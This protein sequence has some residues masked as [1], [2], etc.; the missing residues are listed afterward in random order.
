MLSRPR[1]A[2]APWPSRASPRTST[3]TALL[4]HR[5]GCCCGP[6]PCSVH[7]CCPCHLHPRRRPCRCPCHLHPRRRPCHLHPRRR[8]PR[9]LRCPPGHLRRP[10]GGHP[11]RR[12]RR[13]ARL[14]RAA[15]QDRGCRPCRP[16][17]GCPPLR[18]RSPRRGSLP[19]R[20]PCCSC[21]CCPCCCC[22]CC[23]CSCCCC[24]P[25]C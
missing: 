12:Q 22:P 7:P 24:C 16:V 25:C 9:H 2:F 19:W 23:C 11:R 4:P 15:D 8:G 20:P 17:R 3:R 10:P 1:R 21:C 13:G 6:C 5:P 14:H 18:L